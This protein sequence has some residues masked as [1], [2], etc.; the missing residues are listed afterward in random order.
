[1]LTHGCGQEPEMEKKTHPFYL[2][3]VDTPFH[4]PADNLLLND[5]GQRGDIDFA[6]NVQGISNQP[7]GEL[8]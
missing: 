3:N 7:A 1:M 5:L 8:L 4:K 2:A 6:A